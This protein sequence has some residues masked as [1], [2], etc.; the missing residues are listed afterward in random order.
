[1]SQILE[2]RIH[3]VIEGPPVVSQLHRLMRPGEQLLADE[4]LQAGDSARQCRGRKAELIRRRPGRTEADDT[5]KR[6]ERAKGWQAAGRHEAVY[7]PEKRCAVEPHAA[8]SCE[9][10]NRAATS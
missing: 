1:S 5:H 4:F 9:K 10:I 3:C 8:I 7:C 6:F 2:M